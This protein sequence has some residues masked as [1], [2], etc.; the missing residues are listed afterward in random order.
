MTYPPSFWCAGWRHGKNVSAVL[1]CRARMRVLLDFIRLNLLS[2]IVAPVLL[3]VSPNARAAP[4]AVRLC[5][6]H[7]PPY[8]VGSEDGDDNPR[9]LKVDLARA[10]FL[11]LGVPLV[12]TIMPFQRCLELV[13][14]GAVDGT[15]PLARNVEREVYMAFSQAANPQTAVFMYKQARFPEGLSWRSYDEI[16]NYSLIINLGSIVDRAMES[17]FTSV[18]PILRSPDLP[19]MMLMLTTGR[20]ILG[21]TDKLVAGCVIDAAG[22]GGSLA[23]STQ[24]INDNPVYFGIS[25]KSPAM[26]LLP[27]IDQILARMHQDGT[28]SALMALQHPC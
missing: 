25:R 23:L 4:E 19:T 28:I 9:G 6:N 24:A 20:A 21:A 7:Y 12:I 8:A 14:R 17:A 3:S 16:K 27:K 15:L 10:V 11:E 13:K 18:Q 26:A 22:L 1:A 5:F 2:A